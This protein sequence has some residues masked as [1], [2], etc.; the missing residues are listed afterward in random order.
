MKIRKKIKDLSLKELNEC[1]KQNG[2]CDSCAFK[3]LR[4]MT[5]CAA[6]REHQALTDDVFLEK[7][8]E[9][10]EQIPKILTEKEKNYLSNVIKPFKDR[11]ISIMKIEP[12]THDISH[13]CI[14]VRPSVHSA[15]VNDVIDLPIFAKDTMYKNMCPNR[16]YT[17]EEL[18][19]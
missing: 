16:E 14:F 8:I 7:E 9:I 5:I 3:W 19:L 4:C 2:N 11:V 6:L 12:I 18:G 17:L 13:V 15:L 10:E 1:C